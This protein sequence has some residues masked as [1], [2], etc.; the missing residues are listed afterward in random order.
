MTPPG[1]A[2]EGLPAGARWSSFLRSF[3]I[4]G[5]WNYRTMIGSGF[6]FAMLPVLRRLPGTDRDRLEDA[7]RRHAEHFNAHPYLVGLAI[8]AAARLEGDGRDP[9]LVHKFKTAIKGPLGGLGDNLVWGAWLP[10]TVLTGLV[11]VWAGAPAWAAVL[12]FLALYNAGHLGLRWWGFDVG[13]REGTGVGSRLR[14]VGLGRQAERVMRV[15]TLILGLL[16]GELSVEMA[17]LGALPGLWVGLAVVAFVVG[18]VGGIRAWRPAALGAVGA[19]AGII[20]FGLLA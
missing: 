12:L 10:T 18:L 6:A 3:T 13:L 1:G 17:D 20:L 14:E 7:L 9:E 5:S 15:G 16:V 8:G 19:V 4:Q 11:A 2:R